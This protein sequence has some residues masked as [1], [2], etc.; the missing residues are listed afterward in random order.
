M[1]NTRNPANRVSVSWFCAKE[2]LTVVVA[3]K[4][5]VKTRVNPATNNPVFTAIRTS[6][7]SSPSRSS[8][9][10]SPVTSDR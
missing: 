6:G 3:R 7:L 5:S 1:R 10:D 9:T 8:P 2:S 4:K